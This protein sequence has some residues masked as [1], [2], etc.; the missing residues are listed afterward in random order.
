MR[1]LGC[2]SRSAGGSAT[3]NLRSISVAT[4]GSGG[5]RGPDVA[6][7]GVQVAAHAPA[8]ALGRFGVDA[9]AEPERLVLQLLPAGGDQLASV[10]HQDR[11]RLAQAVVEDREVVV[12][13]EQVAER[14]GGLGLG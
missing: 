12:V 7:P 9:A 10:G 8:E 2:R 6:P 3:T 1:L 11:L 5:E 13:A 4:R 14:V